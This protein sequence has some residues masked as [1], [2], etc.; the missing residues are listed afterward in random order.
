MIKTPG[1]LFTNMSLL[2]IR[3][4]IFSLRL[5]EPFRR[6]R[7][8]LK[9]ELNKQFSFPNFYFWKDLSRIFCLTTTCSFGRSKSHSLLK[10]WRP[11]LE[12][13]TVHYVGEE[14]HS[15]NVC[16]KFQL[17]SD[18]ETC[19]KHLTFQKNGFLDTPVR[20]LIKWPS[21]SDQ[22]LHNFSSNTKISEDNFI[23]KIARPNISFHL[24]AK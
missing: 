15:S 18:T 7:N 23:K 22:T 10:V 1:D 24:V 14:V 2:F 16:S 19:L 5:F 11:E 6:S 4:A 12:R 20:K 17:Y 8:I 9:P 21:G 3:P 13:H